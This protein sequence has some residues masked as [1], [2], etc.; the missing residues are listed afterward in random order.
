M[1]KKSITSNSI[2]MLYKI[3][4]YHK[5]PLM[6]QNVEDELYDQLDGLGRVKQRDQ[7]VVCP[8]SRY[9]MLIKGTGSRDRD[10]IFKRKWINLGVNKNLF[11]FLYFADE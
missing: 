5:R 1:D 3:Y 11:W 9:Y 7:L 2:P 8:T 4:M 6:V 10:N